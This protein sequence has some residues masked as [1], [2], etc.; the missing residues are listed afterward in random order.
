MLTR[1]ALRI[2]AAHD[3]AS[4]AAALLERV[5]GGDGFVDQQPGGL[6]LRVHVRELGLHQLEVRDRSPE[7]LALR[8][9]FQRQ[10]EAALR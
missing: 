5:A 10:V 4:P 8:H 7:L 1:A 2:A 3:V 6:D 9:V